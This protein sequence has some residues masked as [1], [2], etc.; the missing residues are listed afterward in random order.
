MDPGAEPLGLFGQQFQE[1][2]PVGVIA[3]NVFAFVSAGGYMETSPG[4][5]DSQRAS[6]E[7]IAADRRD[8][9]QDRNVNC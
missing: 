9:G 3:E 4:P 5:F 8:S 7:A 2:E 6:H 1:M